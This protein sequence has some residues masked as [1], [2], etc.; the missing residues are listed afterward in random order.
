VV[1]AGQVG[2]VDEAFA[3]TGRYF[4]KFRVASKIRRRRLRS[5][6]PQNTVANGRPPLRRGYKERA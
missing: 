6:T 4:D 1:I 2:L 3:F 5:L